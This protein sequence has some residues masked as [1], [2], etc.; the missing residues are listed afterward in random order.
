MASFPEDVNHK[1]QYGKSVRAMSVYL[2]QFAA[3]PLSFVWLI[4]LKTR[5]VCL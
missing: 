3:Y 4:T 5:W 1:T 2:S